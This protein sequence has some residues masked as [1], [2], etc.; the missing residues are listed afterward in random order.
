MLP[1][2]LVKPIEGQRPTF[3]RHRYGARMCGTISVHASVDVKIDDGLRFRYRLS[4]SFVTRCFLLSF[5][6]IGFLSRGFPV[7]VIYFPL[8]TSPLSNISIDIT[9]TALVTGCQL[10]ASLSRWNWEE[11]E[12]CRQ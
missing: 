5:A 2:D 10:G 12:R 4:P 11:D 3:L 1:A 7:S 9:A 6:S 8:L